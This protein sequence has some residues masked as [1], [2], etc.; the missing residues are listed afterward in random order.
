MPGRRRHLLVLGGAL[1]L[2]L[3]LPA[4]AA[5]RHTADERLTEDT[6]YT[7]RSGEF[8]LGLWKGEYGLFDT[9]HAGTYFWPYFVVAPNLHAKW[10]VWRSDPWAVSL[11]GGLVWFD[12]S[13]LD[14]DA[15]AKLILAPLEGAVSY[16]FGEALT[17]TALVNYNLVKVTGALAPGDEESGEEVKG[18]A[19]VSNLQFALNLEWRW[20]RTFAVVLHGR[21]LAWQD[22]E[23]GASI[24]TRL[25]DFTTA[26]FSG[27]GDTDALDVE[28]AWS[29]VGSLVWSW[30]RF[31]LRVGGGYGNWSIPVVGFVVPTQFF[32]PDFSMW[33][34]F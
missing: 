15:D 16:R 31:N 18:A 13:R 2:A 4:A 25:D 1:L 21:A 26:T 34:R 24:T 23:A 7:L 10:T 22:T 11:Q 19:A 12:A 28:G 8:N 20:G 6:A 14:D 32:I 17:L 29:A 27:G 30:D 33:W 9:V 5:A 3:A